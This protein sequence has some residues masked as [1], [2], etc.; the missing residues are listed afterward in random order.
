MYCYYPHLI[1]RKTGAQRCQVAG[2]KVTLPGIAHVFNVTGTVF[3]RFQVTLKRRWKTKANAVLSFQSV[4]APN[5]SVPKERQQ[6]GP[7]GLPRQQH[8]LWSE[9]PLCPAVSAESGLWGQ[10]AWVP[11]PTLAPTRGEV[12]DRNSPLCT[13]ISSSVKWGCVEPLYHRAVLRIR[14]VIVHKTQGTISGT[15][16]ELYNSSGVCLTCMAHEGSTP[17]NVP[18]WA[19]IQSEE[20]E[21]S[22]KS[23]DGA[24]APQLIEN[25]ASA[26]SA[27]PFIHSITQDTPVKTFTMPAPLRQVGS[28]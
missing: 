4:Q 3:K 6:P 1:N 7:W 10:P 18:R 25:Q 26:T 28:V 24:E 14:W 11:I 16:L 12:W 15:Y 9:A 5:H 17:S 19:K 21:F 27:P 23:T 13:S 20:Q 22:G 8:G 2:P